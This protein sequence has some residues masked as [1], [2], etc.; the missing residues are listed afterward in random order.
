MKSNEGR[1]ALCGGPQEPGTTVFAV[2]LKTGVVVVRGVPA[3]VCSQCGEA[4]IEDA[5]A[6]RLE[7]IVAEARRK[8]TVVE[9]I[10]WEQVA[11]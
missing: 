6:A 3:W 5:V 11:A 9:V 10:Q 8:H 2:D 4:W 1:C 7:T